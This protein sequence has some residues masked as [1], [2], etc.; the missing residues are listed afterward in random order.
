MEHLAYREF[1]DALAEKLK[2]TPIGIVFLD[3]VPEGVKHYAQAVLSAYAFWKAVERELFYA[4]ASDRYNRPIGAVIQAFQIPQPVSAN[5]VELTGMSG[6]I[7]YLEAAE[8]NNVPVVEKKHNAIVYSPLKN[9]ANS[10]RT[11]FC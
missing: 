4:T 1:A 7:S 5:A 10:S 2:R 8:A 6:K 3:E 9:L 11:S